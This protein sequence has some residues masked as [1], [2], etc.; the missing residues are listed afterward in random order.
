MGDLPLPTLIDALRSMENDFRAE[1]V[2]ALALIGSRARRDNRSDSD[3]DLLIDVDDQAMF[4]LLDMVGVAH[5]VEDRTGLAAH[6]L[7]E[8]SLTPALRSSIE[9]DLVRVF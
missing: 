7:M 1:G 3:V 2:R 4:S 9:R 6:V 5:L 8:R